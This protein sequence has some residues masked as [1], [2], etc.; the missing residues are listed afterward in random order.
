LYPKN[1]YQLF[2]NEVKKDFEG[3]MEFFLSK[4]PDEAAAE[5]SD[6]KY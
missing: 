4:K 2:S 6:E 3:I 5:K 1:F